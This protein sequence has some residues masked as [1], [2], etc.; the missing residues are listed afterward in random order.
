[1]K[2]IIFLIIV[3]CVILFATST[4]TKSKSKTFLMAESL[5]N[6]YMQLN[7]KAEKFKSKQKIKNNI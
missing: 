6:E 2:N 3:S 1:M 7:E 4:K 5:L